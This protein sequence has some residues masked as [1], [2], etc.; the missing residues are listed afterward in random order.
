MKVEI[1][2]VTPTIAKEWLGRNSKNRPLR[3]QH[4]ANLAAAFARGEYVMTHQGVAFG[5]DGELIDGQHRLS[6]IASLS[7]DMAFPMLVTH[8]LDRQ[9]AFKVID[10]GAAIRNMG[11]VL[12]I[13]RRIA[14]C[15]SML[16]RVMFGRSSGITPTVAQP[17][18][19]YIHAE[20][21]ELLDFCPTAAKTW[22][23]VPVRC[24]AI[25]MMKT[26]DREYVKHIYRAMVLARFDEMP[27]VAQALFRNALSGTTAASQSYDLMA[28]C[29]KV[30][31]PEC[32]HLTKLQISNQ[33]T[34]IAEL[35][36]FLLRE[37]QK[38]KAP[39]LS[40][41]AKGVAV[42]DSSRLVA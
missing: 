9:T 29:I 15:A 11:D 5:S 16:A 39:S 42:V 8:N 14:E 30:F 23:S 24:A 20:A 35:R 37:V 22:S 19:Q 13:D 28:R 7:D 21:A 36:D 4:V 6:A 25:Y 33:S 38:K 27:P 41:G 1:I 32:A 26:A 10:T 40:L 2:H 17:L 3:K 12:C 34:L 18:A 31:N